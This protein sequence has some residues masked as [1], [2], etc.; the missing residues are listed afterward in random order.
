M[1]AT[2]T[3]LRNVRIDDDLWQTAKARAA[4]NGEGLSE[5]IR[6]KLTEYVNEPM[7]N[8]PPTTA[9]TGTE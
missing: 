6:R 4:A 1:K 9:P 5:V 3:P 8:T 2:H 7:D